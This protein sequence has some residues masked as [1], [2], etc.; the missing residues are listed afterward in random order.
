MLNKKIIPAGSTIAVALSGGKD[1]IVLL[2]LLLKASNEL[3]INVKALNVEHGIRGEESVRDS[4]FVKNYCNE[5]SVPLLQRSFNCVEYSKQLGLS[6]EEGARKFRYQFFLDCIKEGFCDFV[7]TAHHLSDNVETILFNL[8][9]GAS[10]SGLTGINEL[11]FDGKIIR[12]LLN[13]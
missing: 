9:R 3:K 4:E 10:P 7:A 13:C 2:N 5:L 11:G 8:F 6:V 12:P 1:S